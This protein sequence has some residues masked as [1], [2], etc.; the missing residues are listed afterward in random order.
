MT[1]FRFFY[2]TTPNKSTAKKIAKTLIQEKL[3]ACANILPGMN[4]IYRWQGKIE[5]AHE[6]ILI[7]K[8]HKKMTTKITQRVKQLHPYQVPCVLSFSVASG[9]AD[10]LQWLEMCLKE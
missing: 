2:V 8:S 1:N 4:S 6:C 7:L 9:N 5:Q 3:I 10:Y